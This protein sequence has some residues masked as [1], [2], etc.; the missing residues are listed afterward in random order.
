MN[1]FQGLYPPVIT[2]FDRDGGVNFDAMKEHADFLIQ[3]GVSGLT[4]LGT[5]G[6]FSV[7]T[8]AQKLLLI[9]TMV[10]YVKDRVQVFVGIGDTCLENSV[11]L[12]NAALRTGADA[13]LALI[14]YFSIYARANVRAYYTELA[15]R[16]DLPLILYN[17]PSLTGFDLDTDLV[18]E[19]LADCPGICGIKDTVEEQAH[20]LG[21]LALKK[22]RPDFRVFCAY[23][24]QAL[25]MVQSG[26]DGFI[27]ATAN[28]APGP[29]LGLIE[30][31]KAGDPD[32]L[33]RCW[34]KMCLAAQ[35]YQYSTPLLLAVK[36][37]VYQTLPNVRGYEKLPGLPL[38]PS[39]VQAIS[40]L[41]HTL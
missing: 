24:S 7:M 13:V 3:S 28:F 11:E 31:H 19:L 26:V 32:E 15:K 37:A 29:T 16:V 14:P 41:L 27:N 40:E 35:V 25:E 17:F 10:P 30:A 39:S 1:H 33:R 36:E 23:E 38:Q 6:E 20:L 2:I 4:Y 12:A 21:M 22:K 8:Q 9:Q 18:E 34:D 5:S